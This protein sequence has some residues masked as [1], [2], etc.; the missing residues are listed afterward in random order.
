M[1]DLALDI[2][3]SLVDASNNPSA[4]ERS[5]I[6]REVAALF[7]R[8]SSQYSAVQVDLFDK[9]LIKLIDQIEE[10][11]RVYLSEALSSLG[12]APRR[13][14]KRL[15]S[16]DA[17]ATAAPVL[18]HS[19]CLDEDFLIACAKS[20]SPAHLIAMSSRKTISP[21]LTDVLIDRGNDQ[22]VLTLARNNGA[23]FS[24]HGCSVI[25]E[26]AQGDHQLA[27]VIWKRS[28]IPRQEVLALF[29]K[30]SEALRQKLIVE[31][32]TKAHDITSAIRLAS[33]QLQEKSQET[34]RAYAEAKSHI[35]S[36]QRSGGL[37]ESHVLSFARRGM[38]EAVIAAISEMSGL[39]TGV[40]ERITLETTKDRLF[41]AARA[42]GLSWISVQQILLMKQSNPVATELQWKQLRAKF[43]S[44]PREAA[45]KTLQF[46]QLREKARTFR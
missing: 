46:H 44:I 40:I 27:R 37:S 10:E 28:D 32:S 33:Q 21:R 3:G 45:A 4:A 34:S 9:V 8:Q 25:V 16:D 2:S 24:Q 38:F 13:V 7:I 43:Q 31:D 22:V 35:A 36:L 17:V 23:E 19:P 18:S 41:I 1:D 39:S 26:R 29:E 11:V 42:I 15:A 12:N 5:R 6:V 30:A 14:V 20:K